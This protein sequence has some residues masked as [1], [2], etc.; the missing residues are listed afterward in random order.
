VFNAQLTGSTGLDGVLHVHETASH[1]EDGSSTLQSSLHIALTPLSVGMETPVLS[2]YTLLAAQL[3]SIAVGIFMQVQEMAS[4]LNSEPRDWQ[5]SAHCRPAPSLV[6]V[7]PAPAVLAEHL[8]GSGST[9]GV[10]V[11]L[12]LSHW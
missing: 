10:Q 1:T 6:T 5:S 2:L 3:L 8:T 9:F 7:C 11:Q 4:H 12:V